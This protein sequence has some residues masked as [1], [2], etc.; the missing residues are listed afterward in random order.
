MKMWTVV[1]LSLQL[2]SALPPF[3]LVLR[4]DPIKFDQETGLITGIVE[5]LS[6]RERRLLYAGL[7]L[8]STGTLFQI[9]G[10]LSSPLKAIP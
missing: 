4:P 3:W 8:L 9:V 6:R 5:K 10:A 2:L 7:V 1:G